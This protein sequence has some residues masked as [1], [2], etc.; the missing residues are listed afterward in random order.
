MDSGDDV[1]T[2]AEQKALESALKRWPPGIMD[3]ATGVPVSTSDR[4]NLIAQDV[5]G[6]SRK[7]CVQRYKHIAAAV[8]RDDKAEEEKE[9]EEEERTRRTGGGEEEQEKT[10]PSPGVRKNVDNQ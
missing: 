5:D 8:R 4:W 1:W 2:E 10:E 7:E 3:A 6:K 9:E